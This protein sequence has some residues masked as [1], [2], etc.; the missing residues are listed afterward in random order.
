MP[1]DEIKIADASKWVVA[2]ALR[3][4]ENAMQK[5]QR[6]GEVYLDRNRNGYTDPEGQRIE[7]LLSAAVFKF[8]VAHVHLEDLWTHSMACRWELPELIENS[9]TTHNW[10]DAD[11]LLGSKLLESFLFQTRAFLDIYMRLGC[12]I[13]KAADPVKMSRKKFTKAMRSISEEPFKSRAGHLSKYLDEKVFGDGCWGKVTT[14]LR[15][16]IAHSDVLRPSGDSTEE[17]QG[18]LLDW[19]TIRKL[20]YD[21]Y[22]QDVQNGVFDLLVETSEP[23][24]CLSWQSGPY[25]SNGWS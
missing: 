3:G 11:V 1:M 6:M 8:C 19:P 15:D 10:N 16:K 14:Q 17:I 23:M 13:L 24:F 5:F 9:V 2:K 7:A 22:C 18:V 12:L 4:G 20:T 21:R 25:N